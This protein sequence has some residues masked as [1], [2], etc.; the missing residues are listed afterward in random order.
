MSS[1]LFLMA[2]SVNS[3][4]FSNSLLGNTEF[5][6][7]S[8]MMSMPRSSFLLNSV[9]EMPKL[10]L[11]LKLDMA[12]PDSSMLLY[13][14]NFV[15]FFVPARSIWAV[16]LEIPLFSSSSTLT[17]PFKTALIEIRGRLWSSLTRTLMPL[18]RIVFLTSIFSLPES[19][20]SV[21]SFSSSV[22]LGR[23]WIIV[24]RFS[25]K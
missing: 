13:I 4:A 15:L 7:I 1:A 16:K 18:G 17:P 8:E 6:K 11:P 3:F 10:L 14:L 5:V 19:N 20:R 2:A 24:L 25:F 22:S 21:S 12:P 23:S 9:M